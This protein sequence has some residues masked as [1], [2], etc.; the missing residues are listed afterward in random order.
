MLKKIFRKLFVTGYVLAIV[1]FLIACLSPFLNPAQWWFF[2]FL[3]LA[4]PYIF[5]TLIIYFIIF[6]IGRSKWCFAALI[7]FII[8][9]KS[10]YAA[11]GFHVGSSFAKTKPASHLRVM[12]WN[13]RGLYPFKKQ[14]NGPML[15]EYLDEMFGIIEA[16]SPDVLA[17]QEFSSNPKSKRFNNRKR[18]TDMGYRFSFFPLDSSHHTKKDQ[19]TA[20]FSKFPIIDSVSI[21]LP[22][23]EEDGT[24]NLLHADILYQ[25]DTIR[26]FSGH[27]QSYRFMRNDYSDLAKIRNDSEERMDASKNIVRK[28]RIAFQKRGEQAD[29][30]K[31]KVEDTNHP[32]IFCGDL[33]DVPNSYA[34]FSV[35]GDK[36][37]A[38]IRKAFGFGQT[39]YSF[40]SLSMRKI[41][42]LR[43]DY[44]FADP[45]FKI[46][47]TTRIKEILSDHIPVVTD[48]SLSPKD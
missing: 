43:I 25:K 48:L 7:C 1:F 15:S 12:T 39:Y 24:E 46:E 33:N 37:D 36:K 5:I 2:G 31:K 21:T 13:M 27:L 3:G 42:T 4:F 20:I 35:K 14:I 45:R 8:G 34:Y 32:E 18:L 38:Y 19:G 30:I 17:I 44:I 9:W 11:F 29:F 47:Q 41:P 40:T 10:I 28:M 16:Y 6:A 26:V 22:Y 23:S